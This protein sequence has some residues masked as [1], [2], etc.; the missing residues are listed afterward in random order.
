M[1]RKTNLLPFLII[2]ILFFLMNSYV[3]SG[4]HTLSSHPSITPTFWTFITL[5]TAALAYAM[6]RMRDN[7]MDIF[8]KI[9][10]HAFLVL[11]VAEFVFILMLLPADVYRLFAGK[12]RNG[13]WVE[14][15][16]FL[17]LLT[18]LIF[19]Y[20]I[21]KGK[22]AYR[23]IKHTLFFDDLP[24]NFDGFTITQISDVHAGSFQNPKA[25]QR[26]IDLIKAQQSDLF[27]FTGDLVNNKAEEI[28]P[29]ISYFSQIKAP[30][31]Q[32]SILGNHDYGD[33]IKWESETEKSTNLQLLKK[34]HQELGFR[35]LLDEHVTLHKDT[36]QIILAGV[37]NWGIG[38]GERGDLNKAMIDVRPNDF[39]ILLSHDP[40]H[41]DE[42]VKKLPSK[43]HL[44]LSG[45]THGMQFGIEA[46]GIKWSPVKYRYSHWAGIASE[47]GRYL[48]I[49]RGFGFLG[50]SG[51]IGIWPEITVIELKR[52]GK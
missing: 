36:E 2:A 38:F 10:T 46:F 26:G 47:N 33:Y 17:F 22:Y 5:I 24:Q 44:T 15:A 30:F 34:Y 45:H 14:F 6:Q 28:K 13:Y 8:F 40:T 27:V 39:K 25:V 48:N 21:I 16:A 19:I 29:W 18:I 51:R 52:S 42:E 43:I 35:L 7:G 32:F 49:N 3:L 9:A 12:P 20:G 11:F 31:G 23:V 37:E 41:W 4:I 50:F 1:K